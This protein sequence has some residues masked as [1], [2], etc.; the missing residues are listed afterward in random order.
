[1][2]QR[3]TEYRGK[4]IDV[5]LQEF[6]FPNGTRGEMEVVDHPG[7]AAVAAVN[8]RREICLIKQYRHL[9]DRWFWEL[10]AG[11]RD[12]NEDPLITAKRELEEETGVRAN[13]WSELGAMYSSPGVFNEVVHL[14]F[15]RDL[16]HGTAHTDTHESLSVHWIPLEDALRMAHSGEIDDAKTVV[17]LMRLPPQ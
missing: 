13:C 15:A 12:G 4:V 6:E 9:F 5:Y 11:K 10:P 16:S 7:G 3:K 8:T 2:T 17:A 1:M 14:Y